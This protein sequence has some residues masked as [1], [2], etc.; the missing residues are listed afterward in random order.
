MADGQVQTEAVQE[1]VLAQLL[2]ELT[3]E[4]RQGRQPD[5]DRYAAQHP[6]LAQELRELWAVAQLAG[7]FAPAA[8]IDRPTLNPSSSA[9][10]SVSG[11]ALPR[12][13]GN[14][15]LLEELGRGGMGVVYKARQ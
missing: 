8:T 3:E 5:V 9:S 7:E 10:D 15:E 1:E 12:K 13:F 14:Y 4:R 2:A 11:A 6:A